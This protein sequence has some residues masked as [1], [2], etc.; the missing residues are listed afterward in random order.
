MLKK[1]KFISP[2]RPMPVDDKDSAS[3]ITS[4]TGE[5]V[6]LYY[7]NAGTRTIDAGQ[8]AGVVV[9]GVLAYDNVKNQAGTMEG[10]VQ[11]SSLTFTS[12]ALTTEKNF[13]NLKFEMM[14]ETAPGSRAAGICADLA[15]GEYIVDYTHGIIYGKKASTQVTLTATAYKVRNNSVTV[16]TGDIEIGAVELKNATT[17]DRAV[18]NAA[19][20]ARTTSTN[21]LVVQ[22]LGADGKII[23][24]SVGV[25]GGGLSTYIFTPLNSF[26]HGTSAYGS[27]TTFT[28]SGH[29]FSPE[30]TAIV[31]VDRYNSSGVFQE[32]LSPNKVTITCV[33]TAGVT[34]YTYAAG[35][36]S[37]GDLFM[38][39]QAGPERTI[40]NS[41]DSAR[42]EET[43]PISLQ[44]IEESLVDTTNQAASQA[45]FPSASGMAMLGYENFSITGKYIDGDAVTTT[46]IVQGT[47]DEDTT[48]ADWVS[49]QG[50]VQ[51]VSGTVTG[52]ISGSVASVVPGSMASSLITAAAQTITFAWTFLAMNYRYI[53]VGVLPGD[54]TNTLI[55]KIRRSN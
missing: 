20:T 15:N 37:A 41:T 13:D 24:S 14:D 35:T 29:S 44:V 25:S 50:Q 28:V 21:V 9:E 1:Q 36:F 27:G 38:V 7:Y 46:F 22:P 5:T 39:Y 6:Q 18:I 17:D 48:N 11:D 51:G 8:V 54:A 31:K 52:L 26:G 16:V 55:I 12:T 3:I 40:T 49:L 45:Y 10:T 34:T 47:N 30:A 2:Q 53:R 33:T 42:V 23:D 4:V 19:N 32:T 43:N